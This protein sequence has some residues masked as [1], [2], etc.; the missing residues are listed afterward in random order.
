MRIAI[1]R[2]ESLSDNIP[3]R[4]DSCNNTIFYTN[5]KTISLLHRL[6]GSGITRINRGEKWPVL[7]ENDSAGRILL[8]RCRPSQ[9]ITVF[10]A[11]NV[12]SGSSKK[13]YMR[14]CSSTFHSQQ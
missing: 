4:V 14:S 7:N 2:A 1:R 8:V 10:W 9:E 12:S 11:H 6:L 5:R 3:P 13:P